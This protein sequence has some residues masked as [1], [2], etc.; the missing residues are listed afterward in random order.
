MVLV[1]PSFPAHPNDL[2]YLASA[3]IVAQAAR[4]ALGIPG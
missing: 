2:S 3:P 1:P 4:T